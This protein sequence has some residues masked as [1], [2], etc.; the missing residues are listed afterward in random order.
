MFRASEPSK[1]QF[2]GE[3]QSGLL[4]ANAAGKPLSQTNVLRRSL[5][6]ILKELGVDK[7]GFHAMR[8]FHT[9][10]LRK[11]RTPEDLVK[12]WMGHAKSS[13]TDDYSKLKEDV[14]YRYEVAEAIRTGFTVPESMRPMRPKKSRK[15]EMEF[16]A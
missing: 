10:W 16:S 8:R 7:T 1:L 14:P 2:V 12:F 4:F 11:R 15:M 5:H 13:V 9:T 6:P 3:R